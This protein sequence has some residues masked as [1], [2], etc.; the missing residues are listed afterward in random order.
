MQL[1]QKIQQSI[2]GATQPQLDEALRDMKRSEA[3][4]NANPALLNPLKAKIAG[5]QRG[6][7]RSSAL[8]VK[9]AETSVAPQA[10]PNA[11]PKGEA[12]TGHRNWK[13]FDMNNVE[14]LTDDELDSLHDFKLKQIARLNRIRQIAELEGQAVDLQ[15]QSVSQQQASLDLE[16]EFKRVAAQLEV[17]KANAESLLQKTTEVAKRM[18]SNE[19]DRQFD[20][21]DQI[22]EAGKK[23]VLPAEVNALRARQRQVLSMNQAQGIL[24]QTPM[25][26]AGSPTQSM[27]TIDL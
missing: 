18:A 3:D 23:T 11:A 1:L 9:P 26:L 22:E 13:A 21:L 8:I 17:K 14:E 20:A 24:N 4:V 16:L 6:L 12:V 2:E 15:S 5:M 25:A 10:Q 19:N 7:S 27:Q